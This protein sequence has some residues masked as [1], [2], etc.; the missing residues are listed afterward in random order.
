MTRLNCG[1]QSARHI[2][3]HRSREQSSSYK[4]SSS[5]PRQRSRPDTY[6]CRTVHGAT[7]HTAPTLGREEPMPVYLLHFDEPFGHAQHYLGFAETPESLVARLAHHRAGSGANLMRHVNAAGIDWEPVRIWP[8]G[9]RKFERSL[10]CQSSS[11]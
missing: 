2:R 6:S 7:V 3:V 11:R 1:G 10:K 5:K 9:N 8:E 4:V